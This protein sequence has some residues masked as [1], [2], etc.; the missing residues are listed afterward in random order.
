MMFRK[1][2]AS[3]F[4]E[5]TDCLPPVA[6]KPGSWWQSPGEPL[7]NT[8]ALILLPDSLL[9]LTW[10]RARALGHL[11]DPQIT[12]RCSH[13]WQPPE[14]ACLRGSSQY[15]PI[16]PIVQV[17]LCSA[18][19]V[20]DDSR[21]ACCPKQIPPLPQ[22]SP[23]SKTQALAKARFREEKPTLFKKLEFRFLNEIKYGSSWECG[24]HSYHTGFLF[25]LF[26]PHPQ[27][28]GPQLENTLTCTISSLHVRKFHPLVPPSPPSQ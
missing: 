14:L 23:Y 20:V 10:G 12:P 8:A 4:V 24:S 18:R 19:F 1:L 5:S 7:M 25:L 27:P 22:A 16:K 9:S 13:W 26:P 2:T 28:Q 15:V 17:A 21:C 6:L 11:K 3:G